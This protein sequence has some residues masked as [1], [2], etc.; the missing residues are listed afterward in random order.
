M[1][2]T[3]ILW[4]QKRCLEIIIL[5][6]SNYFNHKKGVYKG[7]FPGSPA[8]LGYFAG[9][10]LYVVTKDITYANNY[11]MEL[12]SVQRMHH[13]MDYLRDRDISDEKLFPH[14]S[15]ILPWPPP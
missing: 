5:H 9:V 4:K 13:A 15:H 2:P 8:F 3:L 12:G 7:S 14:I 6:L 11:F 10:R 1:K